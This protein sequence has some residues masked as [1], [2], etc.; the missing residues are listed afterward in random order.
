MLPQRTQNDRANQLQENKPFLNPK[1]SK[2][3]SFQ[4]NEVP[5]HHS[6]KQNTTDSMFV[7]KNC[8][9]KGENTQ[10]FEQGC[11]KEDFVPSPHKPHPCPT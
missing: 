3:D 11:G 6:E 5:Y 10:K 8:F 7:L 1:T 9:R 2:I 4:K